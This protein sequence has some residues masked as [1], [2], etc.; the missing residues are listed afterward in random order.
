MT[1]RETLPG[2]DLERLAAY[3]GGAVPGLVSGPLSAELIAGG[4]SN[5]TYVVTDGPRRW[6]LRRP[7][8]G[9]VLATAHDMGR[10]FRVLSALAGTAVPVPAT[11]HLCSDTEPI[12]APFYLMEYVRGDVVRS[13]AA[14]EALGAAGC[15]AV[16]AGLV[17]VLAA[18]HA[19]DPESVGLGDFGRPDGY[20]ARQVSRFWRQWE[21]SRSRDVPGIDVLHDGLAASVPTPARA[22][23]LHG[24]YRLDNVR[25]DATGGTA[26]IT[27]VLD[28]E[29]ATLGDP[30]ADLGLFVLYMRRVGGEDDPIS[31]GALTAPGFPP[32]E[33]L[34]E[35]YAERTGADVSGLDWYV[36]LASFKLAVVLEGIHVRFT[37]GG[38]V[39][40]GFE[41]IGAL[42]GPLVRGGL[43]A[44]GA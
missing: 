19:V 16:S 35:R 18:L 13:R 39:G 7:P 4:R 38:T 10:E 2:L 9:H 27:G 23:L 11:V 42:V 40:A 41:R 22:A 24:D 43:D 20:V 44:L 8:L 30:L 14:A 37:R 36:A 31:G 17:D 1:A 28:W 34:V 3:L 5:L 33:R 29:M 15:A 25:V 6:V 32:V 21:S 12:G 26:V